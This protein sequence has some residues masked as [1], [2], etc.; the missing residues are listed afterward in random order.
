MK[1]LIYFSQSA[2]ELSGTPET[3]YHCKTASKKFTVY[4]KLERD[5]KK[6]YGYYSLN[7]RFHLIKRD[8]IELIPRTVSFQWTHTTRIMGFYST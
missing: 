2:K 1:D 3:S 8:K 7:M 6:R 4:I 5:N